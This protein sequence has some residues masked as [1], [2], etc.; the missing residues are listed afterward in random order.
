MTGEILMRN[1][2]VGQQRQIRLNRRLSEYLREQRHS[3]LAGFI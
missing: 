2:R 3:H 1:E